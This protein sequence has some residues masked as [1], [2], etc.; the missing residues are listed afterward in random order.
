MPKELYEVVLSAEEI[1]KLTDITHKGSSH[2]ARVIMHANIL[3]KTNN[4]D[5]LNRKDNRE[6]AEMFSISPNTVNEVRKKYAT[7]GLNAVLHRQTRLNA[8]VLSKITGELEA[9]IIAMALEPASEGRARWT[10]RL[11]QEQCMER[12][13]VVTI[14]IL[15]N[16]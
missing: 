16:R 7:E 15:N 14:R 1:K 8:P 10:L 4:G 11:L 9:Q 13:Y 3:L 12:Q 5:I 6:I 2:C